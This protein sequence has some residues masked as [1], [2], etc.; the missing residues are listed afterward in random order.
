MCKRTKTAGVPMTI[1]EVKNLLGAYTISPRELEVIA[2]SLLR[3]IQNRDV[4][5]DGPIDAFI[6]EQMQEWGYKTFDAETSEFVTN[7]R[8]N[9]HKY[10]ADLAAA[11]KSAC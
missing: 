1:A 8:M 11:K 6:D 10:Q 2:G 4:D 9:H 5:E 7:V 3:A